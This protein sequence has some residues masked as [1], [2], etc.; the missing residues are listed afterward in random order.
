MTPPILPFPEPPP[1]PDAQRGTGLVPIRYDDVLQDGSVRLATLTYPIGA[2]LW[3]PDGPLGK[4]AVTALARANGILPILTRLVLVGGE[5]PVPVRPAFEG[6]ASF[7]LAHGPAKDGSVARLYMNAWTALR[8]PIGR[9]HGPRPPGAG[10]RVVAGRAFAEHVLT[11][12]FAP[13]AERKVTRIDFEGLPPVPPDVYAPSPPSALLDV[14]PGAV[15][16]DEAR[17]D[18]VVVAFGLLHTDSN[19]HVNSLVYPRLFEEATLRRLAA[20]G[21]PA[22]MLVPKH[23]EIAYR[24]PCFAGDRVRVVVR[25]FRLGDHLGACGGFW[26]VDADPGSTPANAYVRLVLGP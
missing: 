25:P 6:E 12:P 21:A 8:A 23:L 26:P 3:S 18:E 7:V 22:A 2:V 4:H 5:R 16:L 17:P 15:A 1:V 11:R 19:Q 20:L 24:K 10:T 14:P 9:T 13:A